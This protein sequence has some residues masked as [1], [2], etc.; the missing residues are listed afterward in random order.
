MA[1]IKLLVENMLVYGLSGVIGNIIPF[2]MLP[3]I[4]KIM[5][6]ASYMGIYDVSASITS[7]LTTFSIF[8][9]YDAMFRLFFEKEDMEYKKSVCSTALVSVTIISLGTS[10][11]VFF[12]SEE[13][14]Y[15]FMGATRF[16]TV[17]WIVSI[18]I[19]IGAINSIVGA[20]TRMENKRLL[21]LTVNIMAPMLSYTVAYGLLKLGYFE[22]GMQVG[23][24][25]S[26]FGTLFVFLLVNKKWFAIGKF[27]FRMLKQLC[28]IAIPIV[29]IFLIYWI[30]S[31]ADRL[32]ISAMLGTTAVGIY[33]VG[34]KV[35]QISQLLYA[36]FA[37]GW[38]YFAFSTMKD[39]DQIEMLTF[40]FEILEGAAFVF[41]IL[42]LSIIKWPYQ[43][44][45]EE[46][47]WEGINIVP[48]LFVSPFVLMLFQ[49]AANQFLVIKKTYYSTAC[50]IVGVG[51]N[52]ILNFIL[53]KPLG[54]M[55]VSIAS[56]I[57]YV[58]SLVLALIVLYKFNL[59]NI[60]LR[61]IRVALIGLLYL[62]IWLFISKNFTISICIGFLFI[63]AIMIN[64]I[65]ELKILIRNKVKKTNNDTTPKS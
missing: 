57:G 43:F 39:R 12:F 40:I 30:F 51:C 9:M 3:I 19:I 25:L 23:S 21:M 55:G 58:V 63:V 20:P 14:S 8:G 18:G 37:G 53:I 56:L 17:L 32:I 11:L 13:L 36:A 27:N 44:L 1:R 41:S 31:A 22:Y 42:I 26:V 64:Y 46:M 45:F 7:L 65:D 5:P 60:K 54:A 24:V 50:L 59:I 6:D 38:Q 62:V 28:L 34:A 52:I 15:I 29:P 4:T 48:F 2:I 35:A 49:I 61:M 10:L 16:K 33:A 47:Y